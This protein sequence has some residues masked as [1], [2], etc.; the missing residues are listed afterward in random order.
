MPTTFTPK[1]I[2]DVTGRLQSANQTFSNNFPGDSGDRQAVHTVYGGAQIFKA[3]TAPRMGVA[4]LKHMQTYAPNF[5][6]FARAFGLRGSE[7]LPTDEAGIVALAAALQGDSHGETAEN[8]AARLA[9]GIYNRVIEKLQREP[10]EDFRID[11]EDGYGN[12]PDAEEDASAA[13]AAQELAKGMDK[14]TL[15]PF[16]GIRIKPLNTEL[17]NRAVR[18]LDIFITTLAEA[19]GGK[20]PAHFVVTLPKVTIVEQITA[21]VEL[22]EVL[23][24]KTALAQGSLKLEL[25]VE[26]PQSLFTPTGELALPMMVAAAGGRCISAHFGVYDFTASTNITASF[27]SMDHPICD[28]ARY[29]MQTALAGTPI[30]ISD[31][32]TNIMPLPPHRATEGTPLTDDQ[33]DENFTVVHSAWRLGFG[34]IQHSLR[35][36]FYQGWDLHPAQ[37]PMRYAA[38]YTFFQEGW[39]AAALRLRSFLEKAAQASLVGNIFD[40]AATGQAL[41]NYFLRGLSC[42]AITEGEVRAAGLSIE[43]IRTRSFKAIMDRRNS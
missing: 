23:E 6:A 40:D 5:A 4:A 35:N 3:D 7:I 29:L 38:L 42:G 13:T 28:F 36:G 22:F 26:T 32:A 8:R 1:L 18:T 43:D 25:M 39:D 41:L 19:T 2:A 33:I 17:Q 30:R 15:P 20:L 37:L 14:R 11:F 9:Y 24:E 10:V 31:G 34:H 21:L 16:I 27:Q 12:R